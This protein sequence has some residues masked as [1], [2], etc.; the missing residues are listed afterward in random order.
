MAK[1]YAP[2]RGSLAFWP[3]VRARREY[4]R[5]RKWPRVEEKRLLGFAGYKA[6]MLHAIVIDNIK[7]SPT[8]GE[9]ISIP[10]TVLEV[11]PLKVCAIRFY[12]R[13]PKGLR[14]IAEIWA[15]KL[16]KDLERK[17]KIPKKRKKVEVEKIAQECDEVRV[18]VHTQP[19]LA[20]IPKKKPELF[21]IALG[22]KDL[23]EK[24]DYAKQ[25]LGKEMKIGDVLK[26]GE[27]VDVISVTKGKGFA[28]PVKRFRVKILTRKTKGIRRKPGAL[29]PETPG[30][31]RFG[32]P[33]GGQLG[34]ASRTEFN[35]WIIKMGE[36]GEEITPKGGFVRYGVVRGNYLLLRGSVPGPKKRLI[37][38][39][40]ALRPNSRFP[41]Q[42]PEVVRLVVE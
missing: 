6:G 15:E 39:R 9:E 36:R 22:G 29:A 25:I 28:G 19:R 3:R 42:A 10:L 2:R 13:T 31:V 34:Y 4:P 16:D 26:P 14:S 21:E 38:L 11:P 12:K 23:K 30:R 41:S 40:L 20:S 24:I 18:L 5:I 32:A 33:V 35:K 17:L 27:Q 8:K 37:R 1:V 7:F